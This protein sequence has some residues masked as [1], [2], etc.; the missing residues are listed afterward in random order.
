M[1]TTT[2]DE[3]R[4]VDAAE[5]ERTDEKWT[6]G[7]GM[8]SEERAVGATED[9]RTLEKRTVDEGRVVDAA[10]KDEER[11]VDRAEGEE[12]CVTAEEEMEE[13]EHHNIFN[14][15]CVSSYGIRNTYNAFA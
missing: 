3:D 9:E 12:K 6:E 15:Y 2:K 10:T 8:T 4:T 11:A 5:D 1:G 14:R 13:C 7:V